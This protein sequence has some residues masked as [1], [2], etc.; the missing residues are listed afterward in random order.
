MVFKLDDPSRDEALKL[1]DA[2]VG[3]HLYAPDK[4][5]KGWITISHK[6]SDKWIIF[7]KKAL[8][9]VEKLER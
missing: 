3:S 9:Y 8:K 6:H 2:N 1:T 4:Q 5:M 7:T